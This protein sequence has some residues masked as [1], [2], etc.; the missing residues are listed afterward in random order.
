MLDSVTFYLQTPLWLSLLQRYRIWSTEWILGYT[1]ER[2]TIKAGERNK[3]RKI[4][5]VSQKAIHFLSDII[6]EIFFYA[7]L[8]FL[9]QITFKCGWPLQKG[10]DSLWLT[11]IPVISENLSSITLCNLYPLW[12][13][14]HRIRQE[15]QLWWVA[16][17]LWFYWSGIGPRPSWRVTHLVSEL[18]Q[19]MLKQI[20]METATKWYFPN[21]N[22]ILV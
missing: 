22:K 16:V 15:Q 5:C 8:M 3:E 11:F 9:P 18:K 2:L 12:K 20:K 4:R 1:N 14:L 10:L 6:S 13:I 17:P 7:S 19:E 21:M